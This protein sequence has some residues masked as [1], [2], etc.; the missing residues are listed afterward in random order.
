MKLLYREGEQAGFQRGEQAGFQKGE[1]AGR[2][3]LLE[4]QVRKKLQRG[5]DAASIADELEADAGVIEEI[6]QRI[7]NS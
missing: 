6:I 1:R 4:M 7:R 3:E 2:Q 5:K